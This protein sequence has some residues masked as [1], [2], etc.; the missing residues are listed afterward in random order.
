MRSGSA[1]KRPSDADDP[2]QATHGARRRIG[3]A[4]D[5]CRA[6]KARCDGGKP[7]I[8]CGDHIPCVYQE[9]KPLRRKYPAGY[10]DMLEEHQ[11]YLMIGL[12][13]LYE[14]VQ[15]NTRLPEVDRDG[16]NRPIVHEL[17]DKLGIFNEPIKEH[18]PPISGSAADAGPSL[19]SLRGSNIAGGAIGTT[20]LPRQSRAWS[21]AQ[22]GEESRPSHQ[23]AA[24][25]IPRPL[26]LPEYIP[27]NTGMARGREQHAS[28]GGL[29]RHQ[30]PVDL[31][32]G[33]YRWSF[34]FSDFLAVSSRE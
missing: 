23:N 15:Q 22:E 33:F 14:C 13:K 12:R 28:P 16:N 10:V 8:R 25:N 31:S 7:C 18:A 6:Q 26:A 24:G 5:R 11:A 20:R 21:S 29:N 34:D 30:R 9:K 27:L 17:L 2:Y 4:C 3:R 19:G 32:N 1:R